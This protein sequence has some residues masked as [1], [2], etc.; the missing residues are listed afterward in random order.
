MDRDDITADVAARLVAEQFP[1]W[2][3]L[4]VEPVGLNGWDNRTFRLGETMS[5]RLPSSDWYVPQVEKEHRWLPGLATHLPL[6]I[7]EPIALGR[8]SEVFP[9]PWSVYRWIEGE[10]ACVGGITD[11]AAVAADL[12]KFLSMLYA[13]DASNGPAPGQHSANRGG[14]PTQWDE[15]TRTAIDLSSTQIDDRGATAVWDACLAA[16]WQS[17]PVWVHGDVEPS[18]LIVAN[19]A[20][21]AVID[22]GC[23]AVGDPACDLV[24][25]WTFF[26][27]DSA[28]IFRS[29]PPF[30]ELV[31]DTNP[32]RSSTGSSPTTG[33]PPTHKQR[34]RTSARSSLA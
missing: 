6:P 5:V 14:S 20:L 34:R 29:G 28:A 27:D 3:G 9:R 1:Q 13:I 31:G 17:T 11:L 25:A 21:H 7:P 26:D 18:N 23:L 16:E 33:V 2:A 22:F 4:P 12:A 10:P 19:G 32:P 8:P 24:M 15:E 30:D